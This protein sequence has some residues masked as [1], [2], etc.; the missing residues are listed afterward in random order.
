MDYLAD[1]GT[2]SK[3]SDSNGLNLKEWY[4]KFYLVKKSDDKI[5]ETVTW[6]FWD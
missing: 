5:G 2:K 6:K 1:T 4:T 3:M